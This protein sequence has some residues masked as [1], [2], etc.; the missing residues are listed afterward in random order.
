MKKSVM[1]GL[2]VAAAMAAGASAT[3][4]RLNYCV[5]PNGAVFD[6]KFELVLDNNDGSWV[7]GQGFNWIIFGDAMNAPSP[8]VGF[9]MDPGSFPIGP[10]TE[11]TSSGGFHNGPTLG[12]L[13]AQVQPTLIPNHWVPNAVGDKLEWKGSSTANLGAGQMLFSNLMSGNG[14]VQASFAVGNLDCGGCYPDCNGDGALTV[15]DF[16]CFQTKFVAGCP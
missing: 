13:W 12:P 16:G 1:F 3:P 14:S 9:V 10:F 2:A 15:A 5:T 11:L 7:A 8:L 6:Y 4:L